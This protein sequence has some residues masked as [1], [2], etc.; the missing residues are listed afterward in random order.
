M[1]SAIEK[2]TAAA[3]VPPRVVAEYCPRFASA[4]EY[5]A[6]ADGINASGERITYTEE[7]A[8]CGCKFNTVS[9]VLRER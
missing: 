5:F 4:A 3:S 7:G 6:Y 9:A 8:R 1:T 2:I